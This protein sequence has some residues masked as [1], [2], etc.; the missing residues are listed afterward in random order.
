MADGGRYRRRRFAVFHFEDGSVH[1]A[2]RRADFQARTYNR[3]NGGVA[4]WFEPVVDA[5]A[6]H[7]ITRRIVSGAASIFD[8][9]F[10]G[11]GTQQSWDVELY[12]FRI[13]A[14]Q[15]EKGR[16]PR[17]VSTAMALRAWSSCW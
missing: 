3:L 12:Q 1:R 13:E 11:S 17:R 16:R 9:V 6:D 8:S 7:P 4:R 15:D 5:I 2:S 10:A 14:A